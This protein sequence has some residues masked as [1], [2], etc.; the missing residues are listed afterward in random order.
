M[1]HLAGVLIFYSNYIYT[2]SVRFTWAGGC[3]VSYKYE[4]SSI[5][6]MVPRK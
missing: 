2:V 1:V 5:T 4:S 3:F 6:E